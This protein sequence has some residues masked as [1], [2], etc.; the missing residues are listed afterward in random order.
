[1]GGC[2]FDFSNRD[3]PLRLFRGVMRN[4]EC[5]KANTAEGK[6]GKEGSQEYRSLL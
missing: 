1:M 2:I 3:V 6:D 4:H 5:G